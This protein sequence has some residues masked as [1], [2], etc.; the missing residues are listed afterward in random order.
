MNFYVL[1]DGVFVILLG[2]KMGRQ[3]RSTER[4]TDRHKHETLIFKYNVHVFGEEKLL[5]IITDISC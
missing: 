2:I 5:H 1:I 3:G 4:Q